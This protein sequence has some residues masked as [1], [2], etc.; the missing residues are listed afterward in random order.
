MAR[1]LVSGR[2][3]NLAGKFNIEM[4]V[5][6]SLCSDA[7]LGFYITWENDV[8]SLLTDDFEADCLQGACK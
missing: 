8:S 2:D 6:D 3:K 4:L 7:I 1:N 5:A